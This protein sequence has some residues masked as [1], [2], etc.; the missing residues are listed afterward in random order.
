MLITKGKI[1]IE[2]FLGCFHR[3]GRKT[4]V[5]QD[6]VLLSILMNFLFIIAALDSLLQRW[7]KIKLEDFS[8]WNTG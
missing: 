4:I 5:R 6:L 7:T 1:I 2:S 8:L 3:E